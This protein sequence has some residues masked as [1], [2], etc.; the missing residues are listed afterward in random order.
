M[1]SRP[2]TAVRLAPEAAH[3]SASLKQKHRKLSHTRPIEEVHDSKIN[4][5]RGVDR[6]NYLGC[7]EAVTADFK[8]VAV[9]RDRSTQ[10]T[11][12]SG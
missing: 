11:A 6:S 5:K 2:A 9:V 1:V 4:A 3:V 7:M 8:E 10:N 12:K